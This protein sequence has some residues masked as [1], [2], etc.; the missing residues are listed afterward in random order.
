MTRFNRYSKIEKGCWVFFAKRVSQDTSCV[1]VH[2]YL[3][4]IL[5]ICLLVMLS[6]V[7]YMH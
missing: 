6:M 5:V 7:R 3:L 4:E 2:G 1:L